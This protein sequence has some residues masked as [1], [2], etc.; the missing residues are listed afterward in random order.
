MGE[1][2]MR[3]SSP[4]LAREKDDKAILRQ[5]LNDYAYAF[6]NERRLRRELGGTEV[7]ANREW[8]FVSRN[9]AD[10]TL[11]RPTTSGRSARSGPR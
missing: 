11:G 2:A 8:R 3:R 7:D 5:A 6:H 9:E 10:W 4:G 1:R